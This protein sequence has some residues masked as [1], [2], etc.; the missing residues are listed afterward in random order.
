MKRNMTPIVLS[1]GA[2]AL[3]AFG[4]S[5]HR[6]STPSGTSTARTSAPTKSTAKSPA[7]TVRGLALSPQ[8]W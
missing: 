7:R 6:T 1:L 3:M 2:A 4:C 5:Q 8:R